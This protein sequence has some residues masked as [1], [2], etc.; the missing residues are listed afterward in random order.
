MDCAWS[1]FNKE[2]EKGTPSFLSFV[3]H[4]EAFSGATGGYFDCLYI[5]YRLLAKFQE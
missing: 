5:F 4:R 3:A 1:T 2:S